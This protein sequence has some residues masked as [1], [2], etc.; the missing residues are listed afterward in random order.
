MSSDNFYREQ[1]AIAAPGRLAV[2]SNDILAMTGF[3]GVVFLL[4]LTLLGDYL[5][6]IPLTNNF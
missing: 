3:Y 4:V 6:P 5:A 2:F 1:N